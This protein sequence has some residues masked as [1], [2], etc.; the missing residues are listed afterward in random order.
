MSGKF[1]ANDRASR[2]A[3][4]W[5]ETRE[6]RTTHHWG[7]KRARLSRLS[8]SVQ[9]AY[10]FLGFLR[11]LSSTSSLQLVVA[12]LSLRSFLSCLLS[13]AVSGW[14]LAESRLTETTPIRLALSSG[15]LRK[16]RNGEVHEWLH[17]RSPCFI[18]FWKP[19][20]VTFHDWLV[21]FSCLDNGAS[22]DGLKNRPMKTFWRR[23]L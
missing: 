1:L 21:I 7:P 3:D 18:I 16:G 4:S 12:L 9:E 20:E 10:L 14:L 8:S 23:L 6:T 11:S 13:L 2:S 15:K 19:G 5:P 22:D 17:T